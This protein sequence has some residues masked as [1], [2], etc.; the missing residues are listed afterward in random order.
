MA[1]KQRILVADGNVLNQA[2]L[3]GTLK[4]TYYVVTADS[5]AAILKQLKKNPV[6]LIILDTVFSDGSGFDLCRRLTTAE[7]T[8]NPPIIFLSADQSVAAE[9]RAFAAGAGDY[10]VRPYNAPTV[11]AR[12]ANQLK[13][14]SA[15]AELQRLNKLALDANPNT[16][17]PGN[18][19]IRNEI[20]R[21]I[22]ER[23][24]VCIVY[25]D[26]D[27]FKAYNDNYGF[28]KGDEVII[29]T[30]NVIQV[31]LNSQGCGDAFIGH[32]GGDDFVFIVPAT[33]CPAVSEDIIHRID[34]GIFQFYTPEDVNRGYIPATN[35]EGKETRHPLISLSMGGVDLTRKETTS[36]FE[37][38]DICTEMKKAAKQ[39]PGSNMMLCQRHSL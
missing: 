38:I 17:L 22:N 7:A 21:V 31:A 28:A 26:L 39:Q 8:T 11:L 27:N 16:G 9:A 37:I 32:I 20:E 1:T 25:A 29:F 19:S 6:D 5:I 10:I 34:K 15:I 3:I 24:A 13:F 33:A 14:S 23:L 35:R 18:N 2:T 12:I 36:V 30:A 4:D